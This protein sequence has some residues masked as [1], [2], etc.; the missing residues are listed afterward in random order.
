MRKIP[1]VALAPNPAARRRL[2]RTASSCRDR[3]QRGSLFDLL[4]QKT[5][6]KCKLPRRYFESS[7]DLDSLDDRDV[8]GLLRRRNWRQR[9]RYWVLGNAVADDSTLPS[10]AGFSAFVFLAL[11]LCAPFFFCSHW[12]KPLS[13]SNSRCSALSATSSGV[14]SLPVASFT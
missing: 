6:T 11:P 1:R 7:R 4:V 8:T 10:I 14:V 5:R 3:A 12:R 13:A 2:S 9:T